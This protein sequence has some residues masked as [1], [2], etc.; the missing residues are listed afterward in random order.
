MAPVAARE[1][2][3]RPGILL[4]HR[5]TQDTVRRNLHP[6][7]GFICISGNLVSQIWSQ[8]GGRFMVGSKSRRAA[9]LRTTSVPAGL[10]L[11]VVLVSTALGQTAP[12]NDT[13]QQIE[14]VVVTAKMNFL[15]A[16]TSG[17]T[18][19]PI[20]I[21]KV[22]QSISLVSNDFLRAADLKTVGDVADYTPG[23]VYGGTGE[24]VGAGLKLR[25]FRI[26]FGGGGQALD[27]LQ[28]NEFFNADYAT[29]DRLEIV[30]GPASVIY[31]VSSPG[32]L[33]N[34]VTKSATATTNLEPPMVSSWAWSAAEKGG[35]NS[36][37]VTPPRRSE[38]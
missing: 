24:G 10:L 28:V 5:D 3:S 22:P 30:K 14:T 18:G 21:E 19:L 36:H 25:G 15:S 29:T 11:S 27:G 2:A 6:I 31:G 8:I 38:Q 23:A 37:V 9:L 13:D 7:N 16:D 26:G 4:S 35:G 33:V 34:R 1:P 32:G 12:S 17:A 20:P